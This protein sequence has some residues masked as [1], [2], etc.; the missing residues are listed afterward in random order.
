MIEDRINDIR[1]FN[2]LRGWNI[3]HTPKNL[4]MSVMIEAAELAECFQWLT[5]EDSYEIEDLEQVEDEVADVLI[6]ILNLCDK[7]QI[8]PDKAI[9]AKLQKNAKRFKLEVR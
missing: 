1:K 3:Y 7:L 6:Y 2:G 5:P 9:I 8:N 4:A